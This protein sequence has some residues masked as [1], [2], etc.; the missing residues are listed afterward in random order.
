MRW[1]YILSKY[2][3]IRFNNF[4][5]STKQLLTQMSTIVFFVNF[6]T[7]VIYK[8][9]LVTPYHEMTVDTMFFW[10]S[11]FVKLSKFLSGI[12]DF[13]PLP[14]TGSF[15]GLTGTSRVNS[16]FDHT[17]VAF[18]SFSKGA[19]AGFSFISSPFTHLWHFPVLELF[20]VSSF[21]IFRIDD[22]LIPV[23]LIIFFWC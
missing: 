20:K 8:K 14:Y 11:F 1:R 2:P 6:D 9:G 13:I 4:F 15:C 16:F 10:T 17:D 5:Y 18:K 22:Q 21:T 19:S 3:I 23:C 7:V 12:Y